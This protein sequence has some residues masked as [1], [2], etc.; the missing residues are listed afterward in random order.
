MSTD[1]TAL[2][3]KSQADLDFMPE[4]A[5][6]IRRRGSRFA[7]LLSLLVVMAVGSLLVWSHYAVLDEV[8]RGEGQV[9]P[10]SRVQIIQNLEGGILAGVLVHEGQIVEPG[11]VLVRID[12]IQAAAS[13]RDIRTQYLSAMADV[14]RLDAELSGKEI[15]FPPELLNEAPE[16]AEAQRRLLATRISQQNAELAV[17]R[18]QMEQRKQE[19]AELESRKVQLDARIRVAREQREIARPLAAQGIYPRLDY[20]KLEREV[21]ELQGDIAMVQLSIPRAHTALLEAEQKVI[22]QSE[23]FLREAAEQLNKRR[24]EMR[25]LQENAVAGKDRVTRTEVRAPVRSTV[26]VI[27][28]TTIGGVVKPGDSIMELVPLDDTLLIEAR[29]RPSDVAFVHPGQPA[30]VKITA[31]DFAIYGGLKAKLEQIAADTMKDDNGDSYYTIRLR[32]EEN[33]LRRG[34][35]VL[36]IIPGMIASVDILTGKKSV[37]DYLLKPILK[38]RE[39]ALRER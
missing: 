28:Q 24:L 11:D 12:N 6:A 34:D 39:R 38:A 7:Y 10:S 25:S 18:S 1:R 14:A 8:T 9:V 23:G 22:A 20:L 27:Y 35:T 36:P 32:T 13:Y 19:I 21:T 16:I 3:G 2:F 15:E 31:Y 33:S 4:S 17:S 37:L 29:I 26:K 5:A 30:V